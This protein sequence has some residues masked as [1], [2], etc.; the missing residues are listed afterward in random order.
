MLCKFYFSVSFDLS[1]DY[2]A[3]LVEGMSE[4]VVEGYTQV[5]VLANV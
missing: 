1:G 3:V 4:T 5:F 2:G